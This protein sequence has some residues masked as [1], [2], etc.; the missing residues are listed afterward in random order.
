[1]GEL[2]IGWSAYDS[3]SAVPVPVAGLTGVTALSTNGHTTYALRSDGTVHSWGEGPFGT[4][5]TRSSTVPIPLPH[6]TGVVEIAV[7][8]RTTYALHADGTVWTWGANALGEL[9]IGS[10]D[11]NDVLTPVRIPAL[12]DVVSVGA[13]SHNGYAVT[14]AGA[15]WAWGSNGV[16]QLGD[17]Q[18]CD[19]DPVEPCMSRVPV[20][21]TGLG[22]VARVAGGEWTAYA[23]RTDGTV[24][25][26][27]HAQKGALGNGV[28]CSGTCVARTP[29]D[30]TDLTG[31]TSVAGFGSGGY[32]LRADGTVWAWGD[33]FF[34][35]LGNESASPYAVAPVRVQGLSGVSAISSGGADLGYAVS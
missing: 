4:G 26:W 14:A 35:S 32:A 30:V 20:R 29:V 19:F 17:G 15:A 24:A 7:A 18:V 1:V 33:N 25:A 34:Q 27:G 8:D 23:L 5:D 13:G 21:V 31:V 12:S 28:P 22:D 2:G 11:D 6:L 10:P 16:G 9:G 3:F